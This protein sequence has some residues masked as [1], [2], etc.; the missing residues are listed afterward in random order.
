MF[1][2][3]GGVEVFGGCGGVSEVSLG[4]LFFSF[5]G[6]L[7]SFS[8]FFSKSFGFDGISSVFFVF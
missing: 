6:S 2:G 8:D 1:G 5:L 4:Y 3:C 7:N